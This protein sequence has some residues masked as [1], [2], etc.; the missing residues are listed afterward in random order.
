[1]LPCLL[2]LGTSLSLLN[3]KSHN[4]IIH[5]CDW[6]FYQNQV[7]SERNS[8]AWMRRWRE[9]RQGIKNTVT[10][11]VITLPTIQLL[12]LS[13][14]PSKAANPKA[15]WKENMFEC[16]VCVPPKD[17]DLFFQFQTVNID[18]FFLMTAIFCYSWMKMK[19]EYQSKGC[20]Q[21]ERLH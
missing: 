8:P 6:R 4:G 16:M 14:Q 7:V 3:F 9:D 12:N 19:E 5:H 13:L 21:D 17:S 11:M 1:M 10:S 20:H 2:V 18:T 15:V